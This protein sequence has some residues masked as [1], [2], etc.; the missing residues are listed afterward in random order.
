MLTLSIAHPHLSLSLPALRAL[1]TQPTIYEQ[2]PDLG[3]LL[4]KLQATIKTLNLPIP[5]SSLGAI[6]GMIRTKGNG[7]VNDQVT[8]GF[9]KASDAILAAATP[10]DLF[11]LVDLWRLALLVDGFATQCALD[12]VGLSNFIGRVAEHMHQLGAASPKPLALTSLRLLSNVSANPALLRQVVDGRERRSN[13]TQ[14]VVAGLLH[15]DTNV[16]TAASTLV[17][18]VSTHLQRSRRQAPSRPDPVEDGDWEVEVLTAVIE[19]LSKESDS[20]ISEYRQESRCGPRLKI[21][22]IQYID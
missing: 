18:N 13:F 11:P 21:G 4:A 5:E 2:I 22:S 14:I 9:N 12:T 17:F 20:G 7:P 15:E 8:S 6:T 1:S 16:R 3:K 10:L 19:T